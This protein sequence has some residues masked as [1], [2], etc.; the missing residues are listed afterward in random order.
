MDAAHGQARRGAYAIVCDAECMPRRLVPWLSIDELCMLHVLP[1]SKE[2]PGCLCRLLH[3][4]GER[5]M[6]LVDLPCGAACGMRSLCATGAVGGH[7]EDIG[8]NGAGAVLEDGGGEDLVLVAA[9]HGEVGRA[10]VCRRC[11]R[12]VCEARGSRTPRGR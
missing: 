1:P 5:L 8:R 11:A 3:V 10:C 6:R 9:A 4:P 12:C 7:S 2:H